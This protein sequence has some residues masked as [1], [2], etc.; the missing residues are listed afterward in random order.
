MSYTLRYVSLSLRLGQNLSVGVAITDATVYMR[1]QGG[2]ERGG[3]GFRNDISDV[4]HTSCLFICNWIK[5]KA[6]S[7]GGKCHAKTMKNKTSW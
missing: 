7:E 1:E 5:K 2:G 4:K 6:R 3:C